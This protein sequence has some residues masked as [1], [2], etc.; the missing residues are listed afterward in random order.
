MKNKV[1]GH[2]RKTSNKVHVVKPYVKVASK[3]HTQGYNLIENALR[4]NDLTDQ[5]IAKYNNF[6]DILNKAEGIITDID[7]K[8]STVEV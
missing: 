6:V 3:N 1:K 2:A 5:A 8:L 4:V 7:E